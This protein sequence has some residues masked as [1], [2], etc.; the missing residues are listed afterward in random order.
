M[1]FTMREY[2]RNLKEGK[3]PTCRGER[4]AEGF[5]CRRC[6][7]LNRNRQAKVTRKAKTGYQSCYRAKNRKAHLC[8][9]CGKVPLPGRIYCRT[10]RSR[11]ENGRRRR[12][13]L[14]TVKPREY[15][16][17]QGAVN[18]L[19][20]KGNRRRESDSMFQESGSPLRQMRSGSA[21]PVRL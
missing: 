17:T 3:C 14:T 10:C 19:R 20:D 8:P 18:A 15:D 11:Q 13:G 5:F 16:Y 12:E 2:Y 4:D 1:A 9:D 7:E 6:L 21:L